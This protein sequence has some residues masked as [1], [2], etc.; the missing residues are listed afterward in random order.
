MLHNS[1]TRKIKLGTYVLGV[2]SEPLLFKAK[3]EC[4]SL[5]PAKKTTWK[6][7]F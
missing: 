6:F 7:G 3:F 4:D 1:C 5:M 2:Q